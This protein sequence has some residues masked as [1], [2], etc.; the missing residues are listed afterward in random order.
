MYVAYAYHNTIALVLYISTMT[1]SIQYFRAMPVLYECN[2][3][4]GSY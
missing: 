4:S 3:N 2:T 1:A